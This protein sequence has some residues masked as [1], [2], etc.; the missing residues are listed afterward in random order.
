M[1]MLVERRILN[2]VLETV[3]DGIINI[4][5]TGEITRFN[6]AAEAM[7][8]YESHEVI[9]KNVKILMPAKYASNH[10]AYLNNYM[11]TGIKVAIGGKARLLTGVKKDGLEFPIELKI[12]EV[13]ENDS[14]LFTGILI[15]YN[16]NCE[17]YD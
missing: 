7:F 11:T 3:A 5:P 6:H 14:H 4:T 2:S 12:S 8:G 15:T 10:D 13:K 1:K 9:G 16:R 17:G